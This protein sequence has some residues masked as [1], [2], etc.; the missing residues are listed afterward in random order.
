MTAGRRLFMLFQAL[1]V[2]SE[3]GQQQTRHRKKSQLLD[4]NAPETKD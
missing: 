1:P 3:C 2:R 4:K